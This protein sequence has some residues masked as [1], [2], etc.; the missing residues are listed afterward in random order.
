MDKHFHASGVPPDK[1]HDEI[2]L[3]RGN[4][5]RSFGTG[6]LKLRT[7]LSFINP[8]M[9]LKFIKGNLFLSPRMEQIKGDGVF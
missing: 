6:L 7:I 2:M 1:G 9:A 8:M 5:M 3:E 4:V